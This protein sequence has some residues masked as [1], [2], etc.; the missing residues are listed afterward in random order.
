MVAMMTSIQRFTQWFAFLLLTFI[1]SLVLSWVVLAKVDFAY[2]LLHDYAGIGKHI[3][4]Y[5]PLNPVRPHFE[6]TT[7][8]ERARLFHGIVESIH[9]HGEGL[10]ALLYHDR[11]GQPV[12]TL[13][14]EPEIT[15]LIDVANLIDKARIAAVLALIAWGILLALLLRTQQQLPSMKQLLTA[16]LGLGVVVAGILALGAER[17]FYQLHVWIFP[18]EHQWFFYYEKSLMSLMMKAPDLFGY[19]AVM[20]LVSAVLLSVGILWVYRLLNKMVLAR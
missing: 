20:L 4:F 10:A 3:E 1:L 13:L 7:A 18:E 5:G 12:N 14:T 11:N 2:P 8:E 9:Q 16:L 6:Q 19:I 17:V 15:H